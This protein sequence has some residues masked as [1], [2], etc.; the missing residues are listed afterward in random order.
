MNP[1]FSVIMPFYNASD[2]LEET[3]LSAVEQDFGSF[4]IIG[5]NDGSLDDSAEIFNTVCEAQTGLRWE[6]VVQPNSGLGS[7]RN[8][9]ISHASGQYLA[10]L[11]ADDLWT[12]NKLSSCYEFLE[13]IP[14]CDVL[15][16]DMETFGL[17][18]SRRRKGHALQTAEELL[19]K[20]NPLIP[21]ASIIKTGSVQERPFSE[22]PDFH[23]AEDFELWLR[24]L[25]EGAQ[26][27]YWPELLGYYRETG[28]MST[29]L[30]SHLRRV[31]N[32]LEDGY[33]K[34][35]YPRLTLERAK[36]RKFYEAGRFLQKRSHHIAAERFYSAA[37]AKSTKIMGL[38]ILNWLG[39]SY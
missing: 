3:L 27:Y 13:K 4:E 37:D 30:E 34:G 23:G 17:R 1:V 14:E 35:Y 39:V 21:S 11:D 25:H 10:L 8:T 7:A 33:Q 20:G 6:L 36:Q 5:V 2:T 12:E 16:H 28:G 32:V 15:Y 29:K 26:F 38:R 19:S 9:A 22:N 18:K 24:L 31:F